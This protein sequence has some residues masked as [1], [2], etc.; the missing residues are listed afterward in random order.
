MAPVS[1]RFI[2]FTD[3]LLVVDE[4]LLSHDGR[5][6]GW[7]CNVAFCTQCG[8]KIPQGGWLPRGEPVVLPG[9]TGERLPAVRS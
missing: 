6:T 2:L 8:Q 5:H 4:C 3:A 7:W 1:R 9:W